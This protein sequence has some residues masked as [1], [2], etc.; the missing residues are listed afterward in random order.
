L[1]RRYLNYFSVQD[2]KE[3]KNRILQKRRLLT[4]DLVTVNTV[5]DK[6]QSL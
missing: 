5:L 2:T 4:E 6:L 1:V 3:L